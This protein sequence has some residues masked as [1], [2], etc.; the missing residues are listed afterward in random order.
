MAEA[1]AEQPES[2]LLPA[3]WALRE[4]DI[5]L[6][7]QRLEEAQRNSAHTALLREL[8]QYL[9]QMASGAVYGLP[10]GFQAFIR[11]GGNRALYAAAG[12]ALADAWQASFPAEVLDIG[13]GDGLAIQA[14]LAK[15]NHLPQRFTLLEPQAAMLGQAQLLVTASGK[16]VTAVCASLEELTSGAPLQSWPLAQATF[17]LQAVPPP[18]RA[19][20]LAALASK[21]RE[22]WVVEFDVP[23]FADRSDAHLAYLAQRYPHGLGEYGSEASLVAQ[24]FLMPVLVGQVLPPGVAGGSPRS[25]WE[26]PV[27]DW[28]AE[29]TGA[30]FR[31]VHSRLLYRYWW[32]DAWL[33][34]ARGSF[35]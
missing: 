33:I 5:A 22:L 25:T 12:Q 8:H 32:A 11:G 6:A 35:T 18:Q 19:H 29:L 14:A 7:I 23:R 16:E 21:V 3:L 27:A 9:G 1:I 30:G 31:E 24:G 26:Q 10:L 20:S 4:G 13:C 17:A 28:Q 15:A 2:V 34:R